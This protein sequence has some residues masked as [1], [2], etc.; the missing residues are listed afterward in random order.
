MNLLT[1]DGTFGD[2]VSLSIALSAIPLG[3]SLAVGLC[4]S[5]FQA[6]TQIQEQ[7]LSFVPKLA[8]VS[9]TLIFLG[10]WML[11]QLVEFTSSLLINLNQM[12]LM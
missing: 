11:K 1:G 12:S 9:A 5:I 3:V 7:T 6:A 10:P 4:V 8:A 2:A